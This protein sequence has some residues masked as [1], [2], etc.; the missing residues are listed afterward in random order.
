MHKR[1]QAHLRILSTKCVYKLSIYK[2]LIYMYKWDVALNHQ[3]FS[4]AINQTK[5]NDYPVQSAGAVEYCDCFS[6]EE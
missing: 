5:P 2:Y 6:A 4:Y 1:G 3:Q